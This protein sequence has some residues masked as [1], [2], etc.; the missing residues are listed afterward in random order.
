MADTSALL[1]AVNDAAKG[2]SILTELIEFVEN[3]ALRQSASINYEIPAEKLSQTVLNGTLTEEEVDGKLD[4][5][6]TPN[7]S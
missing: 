4:I 7:A 3:V 2:E 5:T 6:W 1:A